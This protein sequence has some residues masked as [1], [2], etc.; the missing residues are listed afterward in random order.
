[1]SQP[2]DDR[3]KDL[4][5][6]ALEQIIALDHPLVRLARQID[7]A[8]LNGRL[9]K[10]YRASDGHPPLP[11]CLRRSEA[12][13]SRRHVRL[14]ARLLILKYMQSLSDEVLRALGRES[15]LSVF[16]RRRGVPARA[17]LRPVLA[18]AL[19]PATRR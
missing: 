9:G 12:P 4:F 8:F 16:L 7:W 2:R 10:V 6:P 13:A 1:M 3:Q 17:S 11:A 19:A 14:M 5:R 18:A 15:V